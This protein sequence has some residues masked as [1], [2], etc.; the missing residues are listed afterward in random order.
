MCMRARI[1]AIYPAFKMPGGGRNLGPRQRLVFGLDPLWVLAWGQWPPLP[2]E[3][4]H[5]VRLRYW[6]HRRT[7]ERFWDQGDPPEPTWHWVNDD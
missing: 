5:V 6:F 7:G 1:A 4:W 3:G 2:A